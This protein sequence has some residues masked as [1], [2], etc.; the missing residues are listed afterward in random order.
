M[1]V[2]VSRLQEVVDK[3]P[4][5]IYQDDQANYAIIVGTRGYAPLKFEQVT[6]QTN[7]DA[8]VASLNRPHCSLKNFL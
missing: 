1:D 6:C 3:G 2:N 7:T 4:C 8:D 5:L